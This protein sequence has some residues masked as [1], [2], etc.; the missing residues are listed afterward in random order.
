ML[1][2]IDPINGLPSE[3]G[4][5]G[6]LVTAS[7]VTVS[8]A[9]RTDHNHISIEIYLHML[10]NSE[11]RFASLLCSLLLKG[12]SNAHGVDHTDSGRWKLNWTVPIKMLD[13][14]CALTTA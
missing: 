5:S 12:N 11:P 7:P 8:S 14:L 4:I 2:A 3:S 6:D 13:I 1:R 9:S 10:P